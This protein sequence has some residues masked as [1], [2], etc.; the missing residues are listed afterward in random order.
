MVLLSDVMA[1]FE[2]IKESEFNVIETDSEKFES[3]DED[4]ISSSWE[5]ICSAVSKMD[6]NPI[7]DKHALELK[8]I[9]FARIN[10]IE[11]LNNITYIHEVASKHNQSKPLYLIN[12]IDSLGANI[13]KIYFQI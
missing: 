6:G 1:Q 12:V 11:E 8:P 7:T 10:L 4:M 9:L 5:S 13:V 3:L 2:S